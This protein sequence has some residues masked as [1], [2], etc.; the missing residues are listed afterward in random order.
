M[1]THEVLRTIFH[2]HRPGR[3]CQIVLKG[4]KPEIHEQDLCNVH[5]EKPAARV[6]QLKQADLARGFDLTAGPLMRLTVIRT[7]EQ[8]FK[9]LWSFHHILMDG[10]CFGILSQDFVRIYSALQQGETFQKA[11]VPYNR[12]IRWLERQNRQ[13]G[14]DYWKKYLEGFEQRTPIPGKRL[15]SKK[16][17]YR[18]KE[19][20]FSLDE[21]LTLR[22][23][24]LAREN[25]VTLNTLFQA[26]WGVLLQKY[27]D[28][29][30]VV[31]GAVVS[32]RPPAIHGVE[33]IV[34]LFINTVPVRIKCPEGQ[35]FRQLLMEVQHSAAAAADYHYL[36]LADIQALSPLETD[37]FDH[38][39]VFE[40]YPVDPKSIGASSA[41]SGG[42]GSG[43]TGLTV[44]GI[45]IHEQTHYGC[46]IMIAPTGKRL[47]V[48][49][50]FNANLLEPDFMEH[51][52]SRFQTLIR[53]WV[54]EPGIV[55]GNID[56]LTSQ[57]REL[58]LEQFND[59]AAEYPKD[60][61][62]HGIFKAKA[63]WKLN[64]AA[65]TAPPLTA[66][67]GTDA[68]LEPDAC[69]TLSYRKLDE[70]SDTLAQ[71]LCQKGLSPNSI[72]A[73][74]LPSSLEMYIA[75]LAI[76][77]AG[78]AYLP[79]APDTP[80][81]R[82]DYILND[83]N[84][85]ILLTG[86]H[87][88]E[89]ITA[90]RDR[91]V[92]CPEF[93]VR[94][95]GLP[96]D[97]AMLGDRLQTCP[98]NPESAESTGKKV[99]TSVD[100]AY[101]IYTS[102]TTGKPKGVCVEHGAVVNRMYWMK[103]QFHLDNKDVILQKTPYTF[104]V[105][106]C[107]LFRWF[108]P[109]ASLCIL[110]RGVDKSPAAITRYMERFHI[111][112]MDFVPSALHV[113]L[114]Y[115]AG[116]APSSL[117][118]VFLK[119]R[120]VFAGAES[121]PPALA[122]GFTM[123][124]ASA[125]H[126]RL[127]NLYGPTEA[128][129]D[130][131]WYDCSTVEKDTPIP[132]GRPMDNA[133]V[134]ILN[135]GGQLQPIGI[136]GELCISGDCLARGYLNRPALTAERFV[137][138]EGRGERGEGS[139]NQNGA[140]APTR[141]E[142]PASLPSPLSPL[143][144]R[145]YRTG[146]L[147]RWLPDGNI[148][149]MGRIDTQVKVRGF[150]IELEEIESCL[151]RVENVQQAAV[152][153]FR[154]KEETFLCAYFTAAGEMEPDQLKEQ[155]TR[156]LPD[157][158]IPAYFIPMEKLPLTSGGKVNRKALPA[159]RRSGTIADTEYRA[160]RDE[161][162]RQL[163]ELWRQV[164][165]VEKISIHDNF[166]NLGGHSLKAAILAARIHKRFDAEIPLRELFNR[167]TIAALAEYTRERKKAAGMP[168]YGAPMPYEEL[169][170]LEPR[171]YYELSY[172]QRRLL[173]LH[174]QDPGGCAFNMPQSITFTGA[175][176]PDL[177]RRVLNRLS[178]RHESLRTCFKEI[179]GN[180][181]QVVTPGVEIPLEMVDIS[182][183]EAGE[184]QEQRARYLEQESLVSFDIETAPLMRVK[185]LSWGQPGRE[186]YDLI[187][188]MHHIIS[189]GW[190]M[191]ILY[192]EYEAF[193][194]AFEAGGEYEP[195]P[196][197]IQ[198]KDYAYWHNRLVEDGER[199][200]EVLAFW[201]TQLEGPLPTA[202]LPF[203]FPPDRLS[204]RDSGAYRLVID[205]GTTARLNALALEQGASLFM[206][207]LAVFNLEL[208][209]LTGQDDVLTRLPSAARQ[210]EDTRNVVGYFVNTLVLRTR[211]DPEKTFRQFLDNLRPDCLN[212]LEYQGYP[213]ELICEKLGLVYP[214]FQANFNM[215][216]TGRGGGKMP[217][218]IAKGHLEEVQK[219]KFHLGLYLVE[220]S[221][222]IDIFCTYFRELFMPETIE[223]ILKHYRRLLT[224]VAE[225]PDKSLKDYTEPQDNIMAP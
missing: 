15:T 93:A 180:A 6:E 87:C 91:F 23:E 129:V 2:Y 81:E 107:E 161:T 171:P 22:L 163:A 83:S 96:G 105:S 12:F 159:P 17:E 138:L 30:D 222:G 25:R 184:R 183:L 120:W 16:K 213:L 216:N 204:R 50:S 179:D 169:E 37:V 144:S 210:H 21:S 77:K 140:P 92:T 154:G 170:P 206:V 131:T 3:P 103:H 86:S 85:R 157:Y 168:G 182:H 135:K 58:L 75:I 113:F 185:I 137:W 102:G 225:S 211:I 84:A 190:S 123:H 104:D 160:P 200:K 79:I 5:P 199:L 143:P 11:V 218:N 9:I 44:T 28:T 68:P 186:A 219:G 13:K 78:A 35:S 142:G 121:L 167:P 141:A 95:D 201:R 152:A 88:R 209:L 29:G 108:L 47:E 59:T 175:P 19:A 191:E 32:G 48:G 31:F 117:S 64:D 46:D 212:L 60:Q 164:L 45:D 115:V 147:A 26:L 196:P 57:E 146:D 162:E 69:V 224:M 188:N 187:F 198:Y 66:Y 61:T 127:I 112:V 132:I 223:K 134:Y 24:T 125:G 97:G 43:G 217:G 100:L 41:H 51:T 18:Q 148:E 192:R 110:P 122:A 4:W 189:D 158:M 150:R 172:S 56:I 53:Q 20:G 214:E 71:E 155:L 55:A 74:I 65:L 194:R 27:N 124:I 166:F 149:F 114:D 101:V 145:F 165:G 49:F 116:T 36:P 139:K 34:G 40:N 7:G 197:V 106:V 99:A 119:L 89:R 151:L 220:Y 90:S 39:L 80:Q 38:I 128:T 156:Q 54:A 76:L 207:L 118:S 221:D 82:I 33:G 126:A 42:S 136:A 67:E 215:L 178:Q 94:L 8:A 63:H 174:K 176:E 203:D 205:N 133:Q 208:R 109:G 10:W 52:A 14:L 173:R 177:I 98:Y 73:L 72:A 1:E 153:A 193:Y 62:I 130:M 181:V 202:P 70:A 195:E 111:T